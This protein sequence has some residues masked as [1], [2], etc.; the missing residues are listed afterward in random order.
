M[1][2]DRAGL[3]HT[4]DDVSRHTDVPAIT[5][6][7]GMVLEHDGSNW[8]GVTAFA[9]TKIFGDDVALAFGA[10][11]DIVALNRST[12]LAADE[13]LT[14]VI[15]G[16]SDH[17]GVA[18]NSLIISN[19][20]NNGDIMM[21]VSDGGNS[22][23]FLLA[24]ADIAALTFGWG[25]DSVDV[26]LA[27]VIVAGAVLTAT[28][29]TPFWMQRADVTTPLSGTLTAS[30][31]TFRWDSGD[32]G[33]H[34]YVNDGGTIR[35]ALIGTV[36]A[37]TV[38]PS[39]DIYISATAMKGLATA[40]AGDASQLPESRELATNDINVDY[41][42]FDQTTEEHAYFWFTFP[43]GWDAG[44][45]TAK[46]YWT[47]ASG[48]GG[49]TW[50]LAAGSYDDDDAMDAALGTEV[51]VDDTLLATDDNHESAESAAIT[52][53][54]SPAAEDKCYFVVARKVGNAND[55]LSADAQLT[56]I[57][58]RFKKSALTDA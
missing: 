17:Q 46:Y 53:A 50:G 48:T 32:D 3:S 40:G 54:G 35:S 30:F 5:E 34:V 27:G 6:A 37:G 44:T 33:V 22:K 47:A 11:S 12:S 56:G 24:N 7:A 55:T 15:E 36:E 49:I 57:R 1:A 45:I 26:A 16:I 21:L 52:I 41:I 58:L 20:T 14:D 8:L 39:V 13:E 9:A 29:S 2:E 18:A 19:I 43:K 42:A 23:E 38:D 31:L 4:L 51:E 28:P 10:D 25:F